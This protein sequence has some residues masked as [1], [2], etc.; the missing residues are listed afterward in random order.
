MSISPQIH[1]ANEFKSF[2]GGL[3]RILKSKNQ[4]LRTLGLAKALHSAAEAKGFQNWHQILAA[5]QSIDGSNDVIDTSL[6]YYEHTVEIFLMTEVELGQDGD[7]PII[8]VSTFGSD[9]ARSDY[10]LGRLKD[11]MSD[12]DI[13]ECW[14]CSSISQPNDGDI[15]LEDIEEVF[16]WIIDNHGVYELQDLFTVLDYNLTTI[17]FESQYVD[18]CSAVPKVAYKQEPN[19]KNSVQAMDAFLRD[20]DLYINF[21]AIDDSVL[22]KD[23]IGWKLVD[24]ESFIE[25]LY[26][27]IPSANPSDVQLMQSDLMMLSAWNDDYVLSSTSTNEYL[28]PTKHTEAFNEVCEEFL[29]EQRDLDALE[30]SDDRNEDEVAGHTVRWCVDDY[31]D[32]KITEL[33]EASIEELTAKLIDGYHSGELC[34]LYYPDDNENADPVELRG[35]WEKV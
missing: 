28:S 4:D 1:T 15:D 33:D 29:S 10:F 3:Q 25:D 17:E 24:R 34:I 5:F 19:Q 13:D 20:G 31:I 32:T 12:R 18:V 27:W 7:K 14:N 21:T 23:I 6:R 35:W 16:D 22:E 2:V 8:K 26:Q 30:E 9:K 11:K